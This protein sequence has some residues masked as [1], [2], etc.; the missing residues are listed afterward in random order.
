MAVSRKPSKTALVL[1]SGGV[2]GVSY[3]VGALRALDH[4]LTNRT[5][6]DFDIY[7]GTSAGAVVS[8]ALACGIPPIMLAGLLTGTVPGFSRLSPLS[9]YR[10]NV[11]EVVERL[12]GAPQLLRNAASEYWRFR[13]RLPLSEVLYALTPLL[14]TG[15]FTNGGLERYI[16]ET[17]AMAGL[18]DDFRDIRKE[19]HI[20][21]ADIESNRRA[22]FS[23]L[24]TPNVPVSKAV[25]AS[26]C[27]PIVFRPVEID[28][29]HYVDGGVKGHA[30]IDV[31]IS[32]GAKLIVVIN[33]LVPLDT[34]AIGKRASVDETRKTI[35]DLGLRAVVNQILRGML[36]DSLIDHLQDVRA[37][38]PDVDFIL[39]EPRPDDEKMFFHEV[40]SFS[41]QL[42]VMQ[43]GY[44]TVTKGL[45]EVW[46]YLSRVLPK[47]GI[48]LTRHV[49]DK[50]PL[51]VPV[52]DLE[53]T[54]VLGRLFQTVLDRRISAKGERPDI[55]ARVQT[56]RPAATAK[57][58][59]RR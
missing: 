13:D 53:R 56:A 54:N 15:I 51:E 36:H 27:I 43:H 7:V 6:N 31:A 52:T 11:G 44:E 39:I 21:A 22:D 35:Y 3:E 49:V 42:I 14:P 26:T 29:H 50:K 34:E 16:G 46:P 41:A 10:P 25:A 12:W 17:L 23:Q 28:G 59:A 57:R 1:A 30:A 37:K 45:Y 47:H 19:L 55:S 20:I 33:A 32:R 38:N 24:T 2:S 4:V 5:V 18:S 9:L 40:M 58:K 48:E 8:A